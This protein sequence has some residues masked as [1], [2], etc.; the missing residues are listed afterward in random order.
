ML[1]P[2]TKPGQSHHGA[3]GDDAQNPREL[4]G[5]SKGSAWIVDQPETKKVTQEGVVFPKFQRRLSPPLGRL[6]ERY[7]K[8]GL[9]E[10]PQRHL[11]SFRP[12]HALLTFAVHRQPSG[13]C[14]P[15][16]YG[17]PSRLAARC[18]D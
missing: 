1:N 18:E 6:I 3:R 12:R 15:K 2:K 14:C 17:R 16:E 9:D 7:P 4:G 8:G 11:F 5:N 13:A 10:N